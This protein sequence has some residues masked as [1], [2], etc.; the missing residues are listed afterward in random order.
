MHRPLRTL[1]SQ[2]LLFAGVGPHRRWPLLTNH[3]LAQFLEDAQA[4]S[5]RVAA[6]NQSYFNRSNS[7]SP[8]I[9]SSSLG[10][11]PAVTPSPSPSPSPSSS[12]APFHSFRPLSDTPLTTDLFYTPPSQPLRQRTS[13]TRRKPV[14]HVR[15]PPNPFILF[16][17]EFWK[18]EKSKSSSVKDH[19]LISKMA[20]EAW[21]G[22]TAQEQAPYR[23]AALQAK[24]KHQQAYPDYRYAPA[25]SAFQAPPVVLQRQ[26]VRSEEEAKLLCEAVTRFYVQGLRGPA[27]ASAIQQWEDEFRSKNIPSYPLPP[28]SLGWKPPS[29][30]LDFLSG[31][32]PMPKVEYESPPMFPSFMA[33]EQPAAA[34]T[35]DI[36]TESVLPQVSWSLYVRFAQGTEQLSPSRRFLISLRRWNCSLNSPTLYFP[37]FTELPLLARTPRLP[38]ILMLSEYS[39]ITS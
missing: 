19:R 38:W 9:S 14:T 8:A 24:V 6:A 15:R 10:T 3:C 37:M 30:S 33:P 18:H 13:H 4:H 29:F 31:L 26:E 28:P 5:W 16:R 20:G 23:W 32:A 25:S 22:L 7:V 36:S 11:S 17:S 34:Y 2:L 12:P 1:V 39:G 35:P 21:N 27:L